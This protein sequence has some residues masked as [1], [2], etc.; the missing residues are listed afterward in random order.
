MNL[1]ICKK[2]CNECPFQ[3][4]SPPGW[5]GDHSIDEIL[6]AIQFEHLFSCHLQ[7]S[8]DA[9]VNKLEMENGRQS[10]CRGF[11]M[12]AKVSCKRFGQNP[13]TGSELLKL[14]ESI[15]DDDPQLKN[16]MNKWEFKT[17]HTNE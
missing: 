7:R 15:D 17:H 3:K 4:D 2:V 9:N 5:L 16:I 1:T 10:I 11:I 12:S 8:D 6:T 14:Q 13:N